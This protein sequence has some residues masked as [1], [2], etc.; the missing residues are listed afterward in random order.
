MFGPYALWWML[1]LFCKKN[2]KLVTKLPLEVILRKWR[3]LP[4]QQFFRLLSGAAIFAHEAII[5]RF[6]SFGAGPVIAAAFSAHWVAL[7]LMGE[8]HYSILQR[9]LR[10][11]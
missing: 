3:S 2:I 11:I 9:L 8:A 6:G 7:L 4:L 1:Q 10:L 5:R